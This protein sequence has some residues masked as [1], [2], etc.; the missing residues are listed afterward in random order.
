M[1]SHYIIE[2]FRAVFIVSS[3]RSITR[4]GQPLRIAPFATRQEAQAKIDEWAAE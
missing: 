1:N 2:E 4:N 3:T